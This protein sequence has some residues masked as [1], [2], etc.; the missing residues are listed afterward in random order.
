MKWNF[1]KYIINLCMHG[2]NMLDTLDCILWKKCFLKE[3]YKGKSK[4]TI[5]FLKLKVCN[6]CVHFS[7]QSVEKAV[8]GQ[9]KDFSN[10]TLT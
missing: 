10:L 1:L 5:Y 7:G 4:K 3:Y 6:W 2:T 8:G 9:E